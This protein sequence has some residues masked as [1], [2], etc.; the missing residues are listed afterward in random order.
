MA[1]P[2]LEV[3]RQGDDSQALR[4]KRGDGRR[5]RKREHRTAQKI[6]R[7]QGRG[8]LE[9]APNKR[10]ADRCTDGDL[11]QRQCRGAALANPV[12]AGD[13]EAECERIEEH[14]QKIEMACGARR[15][16]KRPRRHHQ[17]QR[18]DRHVDRNSQCQDATDRIAAATL[19]LPAEQTATTTAMLPTPWP[20][21]ACG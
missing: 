17:G 19:G 9:L 3:K 12:N 4:P 2:V 14:A 8:E 15:R 7:Q 16:R 5:Q 13:D 6:D 1:E 10:H 21:R 20:S 18:A 11:K